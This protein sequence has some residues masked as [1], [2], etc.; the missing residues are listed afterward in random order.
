[1]NVLE[2]L[3][4][5][6]LQGL[7]EFLPISSSGHIEIG[8]YILNVEPSDNLLFQLVV[9][10]AT[11]L[12]TIVVFRKDIAGLFDGFF[13]WKWTES[14][15]Y[16][17][18]LV[19]SAIPLGLTVFFLEEYINILFAGRVFFIGFMFLLTALLLALTYFN[20]GQG[21][22]VTYSKAMIIGC[23][24]AIAL[25]PGISRS[26]STIAS[27]LL[28]GVDKYKATRF[29]FLMI[30]MPMVGA[31]LLQFIRYLNDPTITGNISGAAIITGFLAAF[32]SGWAS[33]LWMINVVKR[34]KLIWFS[35]YLL[36][37]GLIAIIS[38]L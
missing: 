37:V 35:A 22:D 12:S 9:H 19:L 15:E 31:S 1:M 24:Q 6:I 25:L 10:T 33:C 4:L 27:A 13:S 30:L 17:L 11:T 18:K 5:G 20:K 2:A 21:T 26:G 28:A 3:I 36:V 29:S 8:T 7:T 14:K 34:G 32:F 16:I 23:A 38:F